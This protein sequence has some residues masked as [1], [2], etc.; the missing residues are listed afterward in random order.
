M[1]ERL[2]DFCRRRSA[3]ILVVLLALPLLGW[4]VTRSIGRAESS[5]LASPARAE[6]DAWSQIEHL[7]Q[8]MPLIEFEYDYLEQPRDFIGR[9]YLVSNR[10]L[11]ERF[12]ASDAPDTPSSLARAHALVALAR[13]N[14]SLGQIGRV[15][16]SLQRAKQLLDEIDQSIGT[17]EIR[18]LMAEVEN[19]TACLCARTGRLAEAADHM[20]AAI[21]SAYLATSMARYEPSRELARYHRNQALILFR[22]GRDGFSEL[23]RSVELSL[24]AIAGEPETIA[25]LEFAIDSFQL[26]SQTLWWKGRLG[27][28]ELACQRSMEAIDQLL[29]LGDAAGEGGHVFSRLRYESARR[30]AARNLQRL[31]SE[32]AGTSRKLGSWQWRPVSPDE[33]MV[34]QADLFISGRLPAEFETQQALLFTWIDDEVSQSAVTEMIVHTYQQVAILL[35][36]ADDRLA[37]DARQDLKN[38]GVSL[39]RIHMRYLATDTLWLRDFGPFSVDIGNSLT[40]WVDIRLERDQEGSDRH[41]DDH[42]PRALAR[43]FDQP[44]TEA[45]IYLEG[46]GLLTNGAGLCVVSSVMLERT[47]MLGYSEQHFIETIKRLFGAREVVVLEALRGE[48]NGHVD[49]FMTFVAPDTVVVGDYRDGDDANRQLLDRHAER[50][51]G[52]KTDTG[53]LRVLRIPMPPRQTSYFGGTYTNVVYANGVLLVPTW[54]SAP[55]DLEEEALSLYR[56]LLPEWKIVGIDCEPLGRRDGSLRCAT[57]NLF[58]KLDWDCAE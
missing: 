28:S 4:V 19:R 10:D 55:R 25:S 36:V 12:A 47:K 27:E 15:E 32:P 45:P 18:W 16:S 39:D 20:S 56:D 8:V 43:L 34:L 14:Q 57:M 9:E 41:A 35:L 5:H 17:P 1:L 48:P 38:A 6:S 3:W 46:G 50:L 37:A 40:C 13:V 21:E 51:A 52:M 44:V 53:P 22:L 24:S 7:A 30:L 11:L 49:W 54:S 31:R 2:A 29:R 26:L 33:G 42:V 23:G 58:G